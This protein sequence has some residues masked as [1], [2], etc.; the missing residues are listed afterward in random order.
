MSETKT[1][2]VRYLNGTIEDCSIQ[3]AQHP[4][5]KLVLSGEGFRGRE[6]SGGDLFDALTSLRVALE[7]LDIQLLCNGARPDVFPSGMS[8]DMSGGR[9]A[10][11]TKLGCPALRTDMVDIFDYADAQ[12]VGTV[13][14]QQIFHEQ[15]VASLRK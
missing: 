6:F 13:R 9:K 8:R 3:V 1:I 11:V 7:E 12:S 15:W 5:W 10:Y 14:D 4:E 2:K